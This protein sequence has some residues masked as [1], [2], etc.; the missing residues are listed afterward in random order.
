[1]ESCR[2]RGG[3]HARGEFKKTT[4][5]LFETFYLWALGELAGSE[6]IL[7]GEDFFVV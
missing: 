4:E 2:A 7:K 6:D 3:G 1:V 5:F